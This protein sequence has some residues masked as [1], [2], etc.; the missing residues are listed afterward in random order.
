MQRH[1]EALHSG[2]L[3]LKP[4][5]ESQLNIGWTVSGPPCPFR[6]KE[7]INEKNSLEWFLL[8]LSTG[9]IA[10]GTQIN[11]NNVFYYYESRADIRT[12]DTKLAEMI[13]VDYRTARDE[14][15][16]HDLFRANKTCPRGKKL[17]Q[18]KSEQSGFFFKLLETL[19]SMTSNARHF[20]L[21]SEK[22]AISHS[23]IV[24]P[25]PLK[26]RKT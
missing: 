11:D 16:R 24:M 26:M 6:T 4:A 7:N 22:E 5:L 20:P 18:A 1:R 21:A 25:L 23:V 19:G 3:P 17:N 2:N 14:F 10:G 12:P 9:A 13:S 8:S 15:T